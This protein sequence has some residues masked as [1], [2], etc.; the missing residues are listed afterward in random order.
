MDV[1]MANIDENPLASAQRETFGAGTFGKYEYQYHWALCRMLSE[2]EKVGEYVVFVELHEDVVIGDS[3]DSNVVSFEFNQVK[4]FESINHVSLNKLIKSTETSDSILIKMMKS[5]SGKQFVDDVSV[6]NLVA[7]CGF[8]IP[9]RDE[10]LKLELI[11]TGDLSD[12]SLSKITDE[13]LKNKVDS[14]LLD[15]IQFL[16]PDLA[17]KGMQDAVIGRISN[18]VERILPGCQ[19]NP[20]YIYRAVLDELHRKGM[21]QYDYAKWG[22]LVDK[23][24]LTSTTVTEV[25]SHH[26]S[27]KHKEY[28]KEEFEKIS[29]ELNLNYQKKKKLWQSV[30]RYY[31]RSLAARNSAQVIIDRQLGAYVKKGMEMEFDLTTELIEYVESNISTDVKDSIG[32]DS[33]VKG[34]VICGIIMS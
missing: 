29:V 27:D 15:K 8:N 20:V 21:I 25:I 22:D 31:T 30:E 5:V 17:N 2:H 23:K 32:N 9:L 12:S 33:D 3:L 10:N 26:A 34:A 13:L 14:S 18:L 1:C 16:V 6:I 4:D 7:T 11:T 28:I 19:S 24:G